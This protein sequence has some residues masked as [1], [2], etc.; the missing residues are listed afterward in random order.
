MKEIYS[1]VTTEDN[2]FRNLAYETELMNY[3]SEKFEQ[4]HKTIAILFLWQNDNTIV[5]GKHQNPYREC[6]LDFVKSN[7][8]KIA[9]RITGGGAVYHDKGNLN[10]SFIQTKD[11]YDK[12]LNFQIIKNALNDLGIV[13]E[14]S[15]RN[16]ILVNGKKFSGNAF[17]ETK[18]CGL[19]HGTILINSSGEI[20]SKCLTP[21]E[22]KLKSKGVK[23]VKSRVINLKE[24]APNV[25]IEEI[26]AS[27]KNNFEKEFGK[28]SGMIGIDSEKLAKTFEKYSS[29]D[30][31]FNDYIDNAIE[32]HENFSWGEI[33]IKLL[34]K[35]NKIENLNI[36]SDSMKPELID[37]IL[38]K[39]KGCALI[40]TDI[41]E[42]FKCYG[43]EIVAK[44]IMQLISNS[45]V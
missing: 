10:F 30:W 19:H 23:S 39:L 24:V 32:L 11:I 37:E 2:V 29:H 28:C 12:N 7:N 43:D 25:T 5:I 21:N 35:D 34:V 45:M 9:R 18:N 13:A 44:D 15:G 36:I 6:N 20:I 4:E 33:T 8:I 22:Y 27:I 40:K 41:E 42:I 17:Y 14:V 3:V 38:Q 16:D 26:K 1:I 31:V